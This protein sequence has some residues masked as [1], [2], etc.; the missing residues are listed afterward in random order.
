MTKAEICKGSG[1]FSSVLFSVLS[2]QNGVTLKQTETFK[3]FGVTFSSDGR[4]DNELDTS[5]RKASAVMRQLYRS[6]VLKRE[7]YTKAKLSVFRL[8]FAPI[9]TYG[10]EQ[11]CP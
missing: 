10:Y 7:L 8:V 4:Q 11:Y 3:Y 9:F 6:V 2:K 1:F 5:I